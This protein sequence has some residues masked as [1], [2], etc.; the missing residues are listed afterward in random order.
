MVFEWRDKYIMLLSLFL[1]VVLWFYVA[2]ERNPL[3]EQVFSIPLQ[4]RNLAGEMAV[5]GL[6]GAVDIRVQGNRAQLATLGG[7]DFRAQVDFTG[8][9]QGRIGLPVEVIPPTGVQVA[10]VR[11]SRVEVTVDRLVEKQV[12]LLVNL[13]GSPASGFVAG[14]PVL[15]PAVVLAKGPSRWVDEVHQVAV[16]VDIEGVNDLV[17]TAVTVSSGLE[18]VRLVPDTVRVVV[19]VTALQRLSV[20]IKPSF[21]G[22]PAP[23]FHVAGVT[24]IPQNVQVLVDP[25]QTGAM[26]AVVTETI[27][28]S[29][30]EASVTRQVKV[31]APPGSKGIEPGQVE[32]TVHVEPVPEPV[33]DDTDPSDGH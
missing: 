22:S 31:L 12:A 24:V 7:A 13:K 28:L 10:N 2:N 19:P 27:N 18:R 11:P 29:G 5:D 20:D 17:D 8:V 6:P 26:P 4:P 1:A 33:D 23:G 21:T 32:V 25:G 9:T 30:I 14:S 3:N 15:E 16:T